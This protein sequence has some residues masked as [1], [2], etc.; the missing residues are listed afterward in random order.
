MHWRARLLPNPPGPQRLPPRHPLVL[1]L[2]LPLVFGERL[3]SV[4]VFVVEEVRKPV[5][6]DFPEAEVAGGGDGLLCVGMER[7]SSK[8]P[9]RE[10]GG[11]GER[12]SRSV[13]GSKWSR[14]DDCEGEDEF[15]RSVGPPG[16]GEELELGSEDGD[17]LNGRE[18]K[19]DGQEVELNVRDERAI[20]GEVAKGVDGDLHDTSIKKRKKG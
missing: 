7:D 18:R 3:G 17:L 6:R 9:G 11:K 2:D 10:K 12:V 20:E 1:D 16:D 13:E 4:N 8:G 14:T 19:R 5:E 15:G